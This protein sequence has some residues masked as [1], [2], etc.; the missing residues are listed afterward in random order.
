MIL[1][2]DTATP[3]AS[4]AVADRGTIVAKNARIVTTH[5]EGLL[6]LIERTL[7]EAKTSIHELEAIVCG[8][9]PGSF[10]G[11]RIGMATAKGLCMASGLPLI[12][13]GSM[14]AIANSVSEAL[15]EQQAVA[16]ILDARRGEVFL[17]LFVG[18]VALGDEIA[19]KPEAVKD[20]L[21][22][23]PD[24]VI[25]GDGVVTYGESH[26]AELKRAP[27]RCQALC[28]GNLAL[29]AQ[30]RLVAKDFDDLHQAKPRYIRAPDIRKPKLY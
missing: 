11:L 19:I 20:K 21:A 29:A 27:E 24:V 25:A 16:V 17:G 13:L 28:A 3:Q 23:R 14:N 22:D 12:A 2:L 9:G 1:A 7:D 18:G 10:T 15:G 8:S 4:V 26:F 5:A 30:G 6:S